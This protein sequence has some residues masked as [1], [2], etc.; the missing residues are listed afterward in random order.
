MPTER[1][2]PGLATKRGRKLDTYRMTLTDYLIN[3]VL[4]GLV[5]TQI[6]GSRLD[7]KTAIRPVIVI[8]AAAFYYLRGFPTGGNDILLYVILG[9]IGLVLGV[10][11]GATTRVWRADD[12]FAYAKAG[13]IAAVLWVVGIGTRLA[14]EEFST[15]GGAKS[16]VNFSVAHDITSQDAWVA[17]LVLMALAEAIARLVAVRVR[18][19]RTRETGAALHGSQRATVTA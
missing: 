7:L 13:V 9:G 11:C 15:H 14:F 17:G 4:I 12:G 5:I 6:R 16:I 3:I 19:A 2:T 8:A 18:G 1:P 10:A